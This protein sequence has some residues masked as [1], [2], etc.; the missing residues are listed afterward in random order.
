MVGKNNHKVREEKQA[1]KIYKYGIKKL[2]VGVASIAI[3]TGLM[4]AGA[5]SVSA[6]EGVTDPDAN[7]EN[8]TEESAE[9]DPVLYSDSVTISNDAEVQPTEE[10]KTN[11]ADELQSAKEQAISEIRTLF[12]DIDSEQAPHTLEE[13][14]NKVNTAVTQEDINII[15]DEVKALP[16]QSNELDVSTESVDIANNN[17]KNINTS[18]RSVDINQVEEEA[19]YSPG[20][21]GDKQSYSGTV[22]V[23]RYNK[24]NDVNEKETL[25]GVNVYLQ[26][27]DSDGYVSNVYQTTSRPDGTFTFNFQKPEVDE[28]GNIHHFQLA[29]NGDFAIRTWA[30]NPNPEKYNVIKPGDHK[31]GFHKRLDRVNESW[32]FTAGINRIVDGQIAFQ[33]KPLLNDWLVKPKEEWTTSPNQD[34]IWPDKGNYGTVRGRVW[35]ENGDPAGSVAV[36]WKKDS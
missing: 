14:V 6:E 33:E 19:I 1:N 35:Y 18:P 9:T 34:G 31:Y 30:D 11:L 27:I 2:S 36:G 21:V 32:D 15:V 4:F 26:W 20:Q 17:Q 12:S 22:Y 3:S 29:G 28:Y 23:Y 13:Y 24:L 7:P 10:P 5:S 16:K 25:S 8:G